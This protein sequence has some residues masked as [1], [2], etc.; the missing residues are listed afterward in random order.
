MD[1]ASALLSSLQL[2]Q[3][4]DVISLNGRSLGMP[5]HEVRTDQ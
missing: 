4:P 2:L 1:S 3:D 5:G